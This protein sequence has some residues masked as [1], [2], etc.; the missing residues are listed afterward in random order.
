M[1]GLKKS[2]IVT[3]PTDRIAEFG[4]N[5]YAFYR[6]LAA[7]ERRGLVTVERRRGSMPRITLV[8]GDR[9][10]PQQEHHATRGLAE[11]VK[12]DTQK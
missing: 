6:G 7:L 8:D 1:V 3:I 11:G 9:D 2:N 5:R 12:D 4:M 10:R